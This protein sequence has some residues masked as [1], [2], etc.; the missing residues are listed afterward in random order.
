M[1]N[2]IK[3]SLYKVLIYSIPCIILYSCSHKQNLKKIEPLQMSSYIV[4][5]MIFKFDT[6]ENYFAFLGKNKFSTYN[7]KGEILHISI[8]KGLMLKTR[9]KEI[10]TISFS[11]FNNGKLESIIINSEIINDTFIYFFN[12]E[13]LWSFN[14]INFEFFKIYD[15]KNKIKSSNNYL[16]H[17][18][19][20]TFSLS[21]SIKYSKSENKLYFP[22]FTHSKKEK[23]YFLGSLNLNN[24]KIEVFDLERPN[25][26]EKI[27][28]ALQDN[29]MYVIN[30]SK[31]YVAF[32]FSKMGLL[33]DIKSKQTDT[34]NLQSKSDT[35]KQFVYTQK[36]TKI[37]SSHERL[38]KTIIYNSYYQQLTFNPFK[39]HYYKL[40]YKK[41]DENN[42]NGL[43]NTLSEKRIVLQLYDSKLHLIN[44]IELPYGFSYCNLLLPSKSGI[45]LYNTYN[46]N[47][48]II[49][50]QIDYE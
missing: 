2:S 41:L 32:A 34:I 43:K 48:K 26:D 5:K 38:I 1:D 18:N 33:Y 23:N 28:Q 4:N 47:G 17:V 22:I 6:S 24:N 27:Q 29:T 39:N 35:I 25:I 44:E 7:N 3:K 9:G 19:Q 36:N 31:I 12:N 15:T 40:F 30:E 14:V 8:S 50:T 20:Y 10:D 37:K 42:S 11:P 13:V 49:K 21:P 46:I 16:Y 45:V